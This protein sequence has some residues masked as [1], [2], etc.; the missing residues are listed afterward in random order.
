MSDSNGGFRVF[1]S[2][3]T[4]AAIGAICGLLFAPKPGKELREDLREFSDKIADDAKAE[5]V[6]MGAKA[7]DMGARTKGVVEEAKGKF[8]KGGDESEPTS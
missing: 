8:R 6:K 1:M 4:G 5:Y 7:K 3:I 2:F